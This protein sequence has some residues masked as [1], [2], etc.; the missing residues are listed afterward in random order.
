[1]F[2]TNSKP[3]SSDEEEGGAFLPERKFFQK[4]EGP[5]SAN[6]STTGKRRTSLVRAWPQADR[7]YLDEFKEFCGT[8]RHFLNYV[9]DP[10][11]G[12][13]A[14]ATA[15]LSGKSL[16]ADGKE[17]FRGP[18]TKAEIWYFQ[19]V[20][21]FSE[22]SL[23]RSAIVGTGFAVLAALMVLGLA[24]LVAKA[25]QC[26]SVFLVLLS[27]RVHS[28]AYG[29]WTAPLLSLNAPSSATWDG[30]R[31]TR[32]R[33]DSKMR[34]RQVDVATP[35][36]MDNVASSTSGENAVTTSDDAVKR[37]SFLQRHRQGRTTKENEAV[38]TT[39][40]HLEGVGAA[41]VADNA[42]NIEKHGNMPVY[43]AILNDMNALQGA[44]KEIKEIQG[45]LEV[46]DN[47]VD[48]S[49]TR[50]D[51]PK[52][53]KDKLQAL[54]KEIEEAKGRGQSENEEIIGIAQEL[55]G[56][57]EKMETEHIEMEKYKP[58][59]DKVQE[60]LSDEELL[61]R[62]LAELE[63]RQEGLE[64]ELQVKH[65]EGEEKTPAFDFE[66]LPPWAKEPAQKL[67]REVSRNP[68]LSDGPQNQLAAFVGE[69]N[70]FRSQ[71]QVE[72]AKGQDESFAVEVADLRTSLR[73][74]ITS[75]KEWAER[76]NTLKAL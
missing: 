75:L 16:E 49:L 52:N 29:L 32:L 21:L 58:T 26:V 23:F 69:F 14:V 67:E 66:K 4:H 22:F 35:T 39:Q 73:G 71:A 50:E 6:E 17:N 64:E 44:R 33:G 59:H 7:Q 40:A 2:R 36:F 19:M 41:H 13:S 65:L 63:S 12:D 42:D 46:V 53:L 20:V 54:D 70:E 1:M 48:T 27:A 8:C 3:I 24:Y 25:L 30:N 68:L 61:R 10:P 43:I 76:R 34:E 74:T 60:T 37:T 51:V 31:G 47:K 62:A 38:T 5:T 28:V 45:N 9:V 55:R 57:A 11:R 72:Q 15:I 56:F 18:E